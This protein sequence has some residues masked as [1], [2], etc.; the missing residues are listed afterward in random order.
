M[1]KKFNIAAFYFLTEDGSKMPLG[2]LMRWG[3]DVSFLI[4]DKGFEVTVYQKAT[5]PFEKEFAQGIRV[6]GVK[7]PM[8]IWGNW[9]FARWLEQNVDTDDPFLFVSQEL[10][11][12]KKI[13]RAV[14][15]NHGICWNGDK[16]RYKKWLN[17]PLQYRLITRLRGII[18]VDTNYINWCHAELPNRIVWEQKLLYVPNYADLEKFTFVPKPKTEGEYPVILFP[19]RVGGP[20][21][22]RDGRGAGLLL[23]AFEILEGAGLHTRI[24]YAG[25]GRLQEPIREWVKQRGLDDRITVT[26]VP[27]DEMPKLYTQ[28]DV[29]VVPTLEQEGTSLSAI[30]ALVSGKPTIVS[31]I[32]GLGNIVIDGL[33]GYVCDLRPESL[34]DCLVRALE[35]PPCEPDNQIVRACRESLGK[36]RWER[37]VWERL[38]SCLELD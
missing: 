4:R 19:R 12:S 6:V 23:K 9:N 26:D 16:P 30:E 21:I 38:V 14:A 20:C 5:K 10:A 15:V 7:C 2:G 27:L 22:D 32:G 35:S 17:R 34:A 36:P 28:A 11:L 8:W 18:C 1:A 33:N 3:R 24:I 37:Q 29:V 31:H 25:P 13:R